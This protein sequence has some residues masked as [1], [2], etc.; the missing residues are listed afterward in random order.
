MKN[1]RA[2]QE[3]LTESPFRLRGIPQAPPGR[4]LA[5]RVVGF[6]LPAT[7]SGALSRPG[8]VYPLASFDVSGQWPVSHADASPNEVFCSAQLYT[9]PRNPSRKVSITISV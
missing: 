7:L 2:C 9:C 3:V 5:L 4:A 8:L 1:L 6:V